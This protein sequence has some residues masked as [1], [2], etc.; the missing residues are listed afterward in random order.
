M[1][2]GLE[3]KVEGK[4]DVDG[5]TYSDLQLPV[6]TNSRV[7][8]NVAGTDLTVQDVVAA[9]VL[10]RLNTFLIGKKGCGKTQ[11]LTDIK[12]SYFGGK[13]LF[14]EGNPEFTLSQ[15]LQT[16]NLEKLDLDNPEHAKTVDEAVQ[17]TEKVF[18]P[19][20]GID[21]F[22][23]CPPI[24]QNYF[25]GLVNGYISFKGDKIKLGDK[26]FS[27]GLAT[28][29]LG[30]GEY[31]GTFKMDE[32]LEDR[33]AL[34]LNLGHYKPL[35]EDEAKI[36]CG[37][38]RVKD[39]EPR[40]ISAKIKAAYQEI[41][42]SEIPIEMLIAKAYLTHGLDHCKKHTK[43]K[44]SKDELNSHWP[45]QSCESTSCDEQTAVCGRMKAVSPRAADAYIALAKAMQYVAKLKN[46][47][48]SPQ[49]V[50]DYTEAFR[51]GGAYNGNLNQLSLNTDY[52]GNP[53]LM[54]DELVPGITQ[55][56]ESKIGDGKTPGE[57][58]VLIAC[59][60]QR[61]NPKIRERIPTIESKF[62]GK[63]EFVP[64]MLRQIYNGQNEI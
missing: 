22:N 17:L 12:D 54:L 62:Q 48:A 35:P 3:E 28:G 14:I 51:V 21:E 9:A 26:G 29:N 20:F 57:V 64:R 4:H 7:I 23:R 24:V 2:K 13:G 39:S 59:Y 61:D 37:D 41:K 60:S 40:D 53:Q 46:P 5:L 32:A 42:D 49:H 18:L 19:F 15:L 55:E 1:A 45:S 63:W 33:F 16:I 52:F 56:L 43:A 8:A 30:D 58:S 50:R 38:P 47:K 10:G 25:Y 27:V 36:S 6:Y 11:L 31:T 34:F 44:N